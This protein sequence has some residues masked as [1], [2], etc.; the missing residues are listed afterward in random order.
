M[1][2][3][4]AQLFGIYFV[5]VGAIVLVRRK[6]MMPTVNDLA[7]NRPL[8]FTIALIELVAGIALVLVYPTLS[9]T[10]EGLIALI[11]WM[12][13]VE[14]IF[15]LALP[16]KYVQRFVRSFNTPGWYVGG[17]LLSVVMGLYLISVGFGLL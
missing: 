3:F 4:L 16:S 8:L 1:E 6:S 14:A 17:G 13:L 10:L 9:W 12:L 2:I 11:G 7:H 15:Y 5:V